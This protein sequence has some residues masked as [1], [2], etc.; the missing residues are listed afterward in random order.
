[1][2]PLTIG[3]IAFGCTFAAALIGMAL[4]ATLPDH[5]L[6]EDSKDVVKLVMG[7]VGTL[8]A[9]L[10]GLLIAS[11]NSSFESQNSEVQSVAADIVTLDRILAHFGPEANEARNLFRRAVAAA[12]ARIWST[13]GVQLG[14]MDP[15]RVRM[16]TDQVYDAIRSLPAKTDAQHFDQT[17]ALQLATGLIQT[18]TLMFEQTGS[19][20]SWPFL[21]VLVFW[22]VVLFLG[23]GL[24]ARF[25]TTITAALLVGALSV[26]GAIFLLLELSEP[27]RGL[28]QISDAPLR[29]ALAQ[30]NH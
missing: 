6:N 9:L 28:I 10:L 18:R 15:A 22:L 14:D 17:R 1:M 21:T 2:S 20:I 11:A 30:I 7:L 13:D 19:S 27:Y 5:H 12:H 24:L 26:S 25:N 29:Y 3:C 8:S 4:H 16:E 23:F